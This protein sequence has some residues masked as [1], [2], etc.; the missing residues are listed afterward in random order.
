MLI[1]VIAVALLALVLLAVLVGLELR[2]EDE[3]HPRR[4]RSGEDPHRHE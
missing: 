1:V 2:H 4:R 3:A